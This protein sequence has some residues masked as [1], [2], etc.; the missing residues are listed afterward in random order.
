MMEEKLEKATAELV[1]QNFDLE[2]N[3]SIPVRD[4]LAER[5]GYLLENNP[6]LLK[7]IFYRIDLNESLL[8]M[9]LVSMEGENLYRELADQVLERMRKKAEWRVKFS[10]RDS[11]LS[12]GKSDN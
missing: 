7:S 9:A 12:D 10:Q 4:Q 8:G 5:I 1:V 11:N 6:I 2:M 3:Q